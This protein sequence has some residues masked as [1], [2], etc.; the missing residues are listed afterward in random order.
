MER[1]RLVDLIHVEGRENEPTPQR[2]RPGRADRPRR[3][4][5]TGGVPEPR[6]TGSIPR[7]GG[8]VFS[9]VLFR[10]CSILEADLFRSPSRTRPYLPWFRSSFSFRSSSAH[11]RVFVR[12]DGIDVG[13]PPSFLRGSARPRQ[14][15]G[16]VRRVLHRRRNVRMAQVRPT[17]SRPLG[18]VPP[19]IRARPTASTP[20]S[21]RHPDAVRPTRGEKKLSHGV[22]VSRRPPS[23]KARSRR[24]AHGRVV[25][26]H[27]FAPFLSEGR[28]EGTR[29]NERVGRR[30]GDASGDAG[31]RRT[32][33]TWPSRCCSSPS[34]PACPRPCSLRSYARRACLLRGPR[35]ARVRSITPSADGPRPSTTC[36]ARG[37]A[38]S[39]RVAR[40]LRAR[41]GDGRLSCDPRAR[42]SRRGATRASRSAL[43][44]RRRA[45][46]RTPRRFLA[47]SWESARG[48]SAR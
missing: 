6:R 31:V 47:S 45:C 48:L 14:H 40:V 39:A 3:E 30:E 13:P 19:S 46:L 12:W 17:T 43:R 32:C 36:L 25:R 1:V 29:R 4:R 35:I 34:F 28:G 10:D 7:R 20:S 24:T 16:R 18:R 44:R 9:L 15:V 27:R 8:I 11:A 38:S 37:F 41:R 21:L 26:G 33:T 23:G 22:A 2:D 5:T 42:S